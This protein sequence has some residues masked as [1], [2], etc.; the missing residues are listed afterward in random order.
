M[1]TV[2]VLHIVSD[3]RHSL[4]RDYGSVFVFSSMDKAVEGAKALVNKI[5]DLLRLRGNHRFPPDVNVLRSGWHAITTPLGNIHI[6]AV[7]IDEPFSWEVFEN[8]YKKWKKMTRDEGD[9]FP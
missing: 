2:Y 9:E 8:K 7:D 4:W 1:S 5:W 6:D 3:A